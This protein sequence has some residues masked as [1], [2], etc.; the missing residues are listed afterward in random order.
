MSHTLS[1]TGASKTSKSLVL[2]LFQYNPFIE[3]PSQQAKSFSGLPL[4][5]EVYRL[6]SPLAAH[7]KVVDSAPSTRKPLAFGNSR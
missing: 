4:Y 1:Q 5:N 2:P 3:C 6:I 7:Q